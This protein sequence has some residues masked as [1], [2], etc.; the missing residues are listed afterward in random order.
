MCTSSMNICKGHLYN[1]VLHLYTCSCDCMCLYRYRR[2]QECDFV[3]DFHSVLKIIMP[4]I[5]DNMLHLTLR[6]SK[7]RHYGKVNYYV[8][9]FNFDETENFKAI[10]YGLCCYMCSVV[11]PNKLFCTLRMKLLHWHYRRIFQEVLHN[12]SLYFPV[13]LSL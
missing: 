12:H 7:Q 4:L 9:F 8:E 2:L 13:S 3:L 5:I 6:T 10:P 1:A 11:P